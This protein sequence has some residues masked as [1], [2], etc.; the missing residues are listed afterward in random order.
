MDSNSRANR[1]LDLFA[2]WPALIG[3]LGGSDLPARTEIET[4]GN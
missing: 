2:A 1:K 3:G 4:K